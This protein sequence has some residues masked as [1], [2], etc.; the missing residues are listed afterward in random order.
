M[1]FWGTSSFMA[2]RSET[3]FRDDGTMQVTLEEAKESQVPEGRYLLLLTPLDTEPAARARLR[4]ALG[5][6]YAYHGRNI[7]YDRIYEQIAKIK[8]PGV[9]VIEG[10]M[11]N[12]FHLPVPGLT[13]ADQAGLVS[14]INAL[15]S[16]ASEVRPRVQLSL[17][18]FEGAV[19]DSGPDALIR[20][21]VAI[22]AMAMPRTTNVRSVN[23]RLARGYSITLE[24]ATREFGVGRLQGLRSDFVHGSRIVAVRGELLSYLAGLYCDLLFV[25]VGLPCPGRARQYLDDHGDVVREGLRAP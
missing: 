17:R 7:A 8:E 16:L 9:E 22:E 21:W 1:S 18:W 11:E 6:L 10:S 20:Y 19:R 2:V 25:E 24:Q 12:P 5:L 23:E 14:V 13:A 3:T 15:P 4:E